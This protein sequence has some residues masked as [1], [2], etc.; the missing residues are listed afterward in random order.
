[1]SIASRL[2]NGC[3]S[4]TAWRNELKASADSVNN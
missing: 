2:V 4:S 3:A 1:V